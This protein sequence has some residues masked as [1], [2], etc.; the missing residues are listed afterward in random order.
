LSGLALG[1]TPQGA[2]DYGLDRARFRQTG[3]RYAVFLHGTARPEK[4]WSEENWIALGQAL[5]R[6]GLDFVLPW[7]TDEERVRSGRIA[8]ALPRARVPDRAPLDD[9]AKLIAGADF[10]VGVDTGLLHLAAAFAVPLVA[11]FAGSEP[12]L[13]GPVGKGPLAV[14]GTQSAPPSVDAVEQAVEGVLR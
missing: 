13:T 10:V 12:K 6:D 14:L 11:I 1:Y 8:E 2:P 3:A 7:G 9:V 4:Q 5:A